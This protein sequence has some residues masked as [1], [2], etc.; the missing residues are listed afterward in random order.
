MYA[1]ALYI[2]TVEDS[3]K[4]LGRRRV[5]EGLFNLFA[6]LRREPVACDISIILGG[7]QLNEPFQARCGLKH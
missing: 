5:S 3:F 7:F 4:S 1:Y 6:C 2:R